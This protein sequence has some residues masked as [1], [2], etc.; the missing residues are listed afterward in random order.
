[1]ES[2]SEKI[3][4]IDLFENLDLIENNDLL[5][6]IDYIQG[7]ISIFKTS[8]KP[9]N[10]LWG[11]QPRDLPGIEFLIPIMQI[12]RFIKAGHFITILIA[13]IHELLD[14]PH[15]TLSKIQNRGKAYK[16]IIQLL[17]ELFNANSDNI[18]YKYGSEFQLS[19][20]YILD[21]YKI[22]SLTTICD[23]FKAKATENNTDNTDDNIHESD[24]KMTKMIYPILQSLD[25]KYTECDVFYGSTTQIN[26]C[27]YS[28]TLMNK[29]GKDN[30]ILYLLQNLTKKISLSFFDPPDTIRNKLDDFSDE[31][32]EYLYNKILLPLLELRDDNK[33]FIMNREKNKEK[34]SELLSKHLDHFYNNLFN[35]YLGE[36]YFSLMNHY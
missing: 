4:N 29:Y 14:S 2:I 13:D 21:F 24:K 8:K 35:S 15:Y 1:M 18:N 31:D 30:K 32:I 5:E 28:E 12:V 7:D 27:K 11:V 36:N 33:Y 23:T 3:E 19:S 17:V 25:E 9:L 26:M 22:S 16:I 20:D 34:I 6:N 10:I